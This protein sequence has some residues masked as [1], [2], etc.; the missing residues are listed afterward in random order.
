MT[1]G[2]ARST[3]GRIAVGA[4]GEIAFLELDSA[5]PAF[6]GVAVA[7]AVRHLHRT[8][9]TAATVDRSLAD[10]GHEQHLSTNAALDRAVSTASAL[11]SH[12]HGRVHTRGRGTALGQGGFEVQAEVDAHGHLAALTIDDS[13]RDRHIHHVENAIVEAVRTAVS[14]VTGRLAALDA[15]LRTALGEQPPE[16]ARR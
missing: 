10:L 9:H 6:G 4:T 15:D 16:T 7:D 2:H 1:V 3:V 12:L 11:R 8:A 13:V 14:D 5:E